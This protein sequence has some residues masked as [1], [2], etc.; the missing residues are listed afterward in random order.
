MLAAATAA[1]ADWRVI[2][3]GADLPAASI[4]K[5][6]ELTGA[7]AVALSLICPASDAELAEELRTLR[8][9][10]PAEVAVIVGGQGAATSRGNGRKER[11][12]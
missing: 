2:Y 5:A 7:R 12:I 9:L 8:R 4:A 3:M 1:A 11:S 10:L 6:A